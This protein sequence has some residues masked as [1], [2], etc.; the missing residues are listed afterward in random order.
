MIRLRVPER[1]TLLGREWTVGRPV[2]VDD[3]ANFSTCDPD[4]RRIEVE[5]ALEG[6]QALEFFLHEVVHAGVP[7]ELL[8]RRQEEAVAYALSGVMLDA[9]K[10]MVEEG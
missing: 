7:R 9:L 3:G 5:R 8:T 4:T 2:Q 6:E 1:F 10:A